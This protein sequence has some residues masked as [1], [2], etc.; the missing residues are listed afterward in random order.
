[1][2]DEEKCINQLKETI[3]TINQ[4]WDI[5]IC[6]DLHLGC[7]GTAIDEIKKGISIIKKGGVN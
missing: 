7:L 1:M 5:Y 4:I 2:T 6:S 3:K